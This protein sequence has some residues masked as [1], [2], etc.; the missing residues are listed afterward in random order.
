[1]EYVADQ[2]GE[3]LLNAR[4]KAGLSVDDVVFQTRIPRSVVAALEAADFSVFSSPTYAKS[5]LSQYSEFLKV[6][7]RIWLD[8]LEPVAFLPGNVVLPSWRVRPAQ[9]DLIQPT[10]SAPS[11][12][13]AAVSALAL[14]G[15]LIYAA[16]KGYEFLELRYGGESEPWK[17]TANEGDEPRNPAPEVIPNVE[18]PP[19]PPPQPLEA[20][21]VEPPPRARVVRDVGFQ[22]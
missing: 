18:N 20:E 14:S 9:R 21:V 12:S 17:S 13:L 4:E 19:V 1:V 15:A 10:R 5:F 2:I 6:D 3:R 8:A 7:A 22:E 11:G 16:I